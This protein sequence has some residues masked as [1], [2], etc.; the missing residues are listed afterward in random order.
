VI[1]LL[2]GEYKSTLDEK[3]RVTLPSRLRDE[4]TEGI[5]Y[6]TR[7]IHRCVWMIPPIKWKE[8]SAKLLESAAL[9][10]E[11]SSLILHRFIGPAQPVEIEKTGRVIVPSSLR[12]FAGLSKDCMILGI[13]NSIELWDTNQYDAF[14]NTHEDKMMAVLEELGPLALFS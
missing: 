4:L 5:L 10:V 1:E 12:N 14:W 3:G 8:I 13:G 2:T 11:K 7:G 6:L 9:S